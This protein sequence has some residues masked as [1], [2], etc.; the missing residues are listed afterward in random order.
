[1]DTFTKLSL[2]EYWALRQKDAPKTIP[3][4]CILTTKKDKH[5]LLLCAKSCIV[6]LGD[7]KD[8]T[9]SKLQCC[10]PILQSDSTHYLV[11]L[12]VEQHHTYKQ[13]TSRMLPIMATSI[14]R[15]W[16]LSSHPFKII[17][18]QRTK[19]GHQ[20]KMVYGLQYSSRHWYEGGCAWS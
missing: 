18:Q 17:V 19:F 1:M 14:Q 16:L 2:S 10:A 4:M 9:W 12:S 7:H 5:L 6:L 15:R 13:V 8:H 20:I 3:T 11:S